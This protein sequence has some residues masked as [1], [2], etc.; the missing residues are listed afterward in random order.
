MSKLNFTIG[1]SKL[2]H[3]VANFISE[4]VQSEF[5]QISHRSL[6]F[7][8]VSKNTIENFRKFFEIPNDYKVFY[9]A[10]STEAWEIIGRGCVNKK[11]THVTNG[12]FGESWAKKMN[13]IGRT[14]QILSNGDWKTRFD[15]NKIEIDSNSELLAITANETST[16][17][18]YSPDELTKLRL[19]FPEI[20]IGVDIT[21]SMGGV[22]YDYSQ[23]DIWHFSVQ[24]G[25]GMPAG[26]GLLIVGPKAWDKYKIRENAE[27]D[28][29]SH[30]SLG[31]LWGKMETKFQTPTTPNFINIATLGFICEKFIQD[32]GS[33]KNLE[34]QTKEKAKF[35]QDFFEKN[36][37]KFHVGSNSETIFVVD[38]KNISVQDLIEKLKQQNIIVSTGY[39]K[40][41]TSQ[42]RIGN[43]AV[44]SMDDIKI[45][46]EKLRNL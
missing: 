41:K 36:S 46:C 16:G 25:M 38:I 12:S 6:E 29:G 32:F 17:L 20:L 1:P 23:A 42:I 28:V 40:M 21:S 2:Y 26:L 31:S 45:L 15:I 44:H 30:H 13:K 19:K 43:F 24:K 5:S 7:T 37:N 14:T 35:L 11:S 3:G 27:K 9:T 33:I 39:G 22:A 34:K 10:S 4:L 8:E 18:A